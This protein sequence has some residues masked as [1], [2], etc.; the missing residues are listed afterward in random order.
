MISHSG[1]CAQVVVDSEGVWNWGCGVRGLDAERRT[2]RDA[3][4]RHRDAVRVH[5]GFHALVESGGE[6]V[7]L[8][9]TLAPAPLGTAGAEMRRRTRT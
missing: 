5:G 8:I 9:G 4:L 7:R 3:G 2:Y 1:V 6:A